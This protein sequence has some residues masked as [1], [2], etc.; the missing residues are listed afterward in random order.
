MLVFFFLFLKTCIFSVAHKM[1][2]FKIVGLLRWKDIL[3]WVEHVM[4]GA[5]LLQYCLV[6][7]S[8]SHFPH[9]PEPG[10]ALSHR[11]SPLHR[12][13][14]RT[15]GQSSS[16]TTR[17]PPRTGSVI[18]VNDMIIINTMQQYENTL[19]SLHNLQPFAKTQWVPKKKCFRRRAGVPKPQIDKNYCDLL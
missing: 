8:N 13:G 10:S 1:F 17:S 12:S 16:P 4:S 11:A 2:F 9:H 3:V 15:P 18:T 5:Q 6:M 14:P 7:I 19:T